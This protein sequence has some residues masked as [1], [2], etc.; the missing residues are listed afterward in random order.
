[1]NEDTR[2][3]GEGFACAYEATHVAEA[4]ELA[5]IIAKLHLP[6]SSA[7]SERLYNRYHQIVSLLSVQSYVRAHS[8]STPS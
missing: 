7:D 3:E 8:S 5:D 4:A 1:M 6:A 2:N